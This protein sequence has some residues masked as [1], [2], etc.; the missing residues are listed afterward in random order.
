M[1]NGPTFEFKILVIIY[2]F[3]FPKGEN[4]E[5]DKC[6]LESIKYKIFMNEKF[7]NLQYNISTVLNY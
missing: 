6:E 3:I 2:N 1:I 4:V 5:K 7:E